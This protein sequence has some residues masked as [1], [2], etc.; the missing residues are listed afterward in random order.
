M[1]SQLDNLAAGGRYVTD[2]SVRELQ[3]ERQTVMDRYNAT[4]IADSIRRREL[5][6]DLFGEVG[7]DVEVIRSPPDP[8]SE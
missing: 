1:T 6:V 3:R 5:L 8:D 7:D 2:E 4:G